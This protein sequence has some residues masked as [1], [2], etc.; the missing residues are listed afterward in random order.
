MKVA[1]YDTFR[2]K[3]NPN[4]FSIVLSNQEF[5]NIKT[6]LESKF[7]KVIDIKEASLRYSRVSGK[8]CI[9]LDFSDNTKNKKTLSN[10]KSGCVGE[11]VF[12]LY[13]IPESI[14][15][16][17][18]TEVKMRMHESKPKVIIT[19]PAK[20]KR[21]PLKSFKKTATVVKAPVNTFK[22]KSIEDIK[23]AVSELNHILETNSDI[24]P[25]ITKGK[26][27]LSIAI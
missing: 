2:G 15:N 22:T 9:T 5:L 1:K 17:G 24:V 13:E 7:N 23:I 20:T 25:E 11:V 6:I 4:Y 14:K 21:N 12:N 18:R 19:L 16:F 27:K 26:I 10:Y 3:T 8:D